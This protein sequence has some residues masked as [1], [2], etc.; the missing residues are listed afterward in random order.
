MKVVFQSSIFQGRV[1]KLRGCITFNSAQILPFCTNVFTQFWSGQTWPQTPILFCFKPSFQAERSKSKW[2]LFTFAYARFCRWTPLP[3]NMDPSSMPYH[4]SEASGGDVALSFWLIIKADDPRVQITV[5]RA[6]L[7]A[8][9]FAIWL[10]TWWLQCHPNLSPMSPA[11]LNLNNLLHAK[12]KLS[13]DTSPRCTLSGTYRW[14]NSSCRGKW[15]VR[16]MGYNFTF[17][18]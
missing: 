17:T 3:P 18:S 13:H 1:V 6:P 10:A 11:M 4:H 15:R 8:W 9:C 16:P 7:Q 14:I 2:H 12:F 5:D